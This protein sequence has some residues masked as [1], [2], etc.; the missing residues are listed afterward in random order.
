M[1]IH[2]SWPLIS[3]QRGWQPDR[4]DTSAVRVARRGRKLIRTCAV[5][6]LPICPLRHSGLVGSFTVVLASVS[7]CVPR[8]V[9]TS[10]SRSDRVEGSQW[11]KQMAGDVQGGFGRQSQT[12]TNPGLGTT[13]LELA[14]N[15]VSTS[16]PAYACRSTYWIDD[17]TSKTNITVT[18]GFTQVPAEPGS[19]CVLS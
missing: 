14:V 18:C 13:Y 6:H 10:Q 7:A 5:F 17:I 15:L 4:A 9:H 19:H 1:A 16:C 2:Q 3:G 8:G 12:A 11:L